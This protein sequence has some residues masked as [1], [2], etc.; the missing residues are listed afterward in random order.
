MPAI[1]P[2]RL[3]VCLSVLAFVAGAAACSDDGGGPSVPVY[4]DGDSITVERGSDFIVALEATPSTGYSWQ[5]APN[6]T[7]RFDSSKQVQAT[8]AA[9]GA[10][11]EQQLRFTAVKKGASLL[12]FAYSRSFE[13]GVPPAMTATFDL[14]VV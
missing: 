13:P 1:R 4:H 5:A 3:G 7:V 10:A 6:D 14:E 8:G 12:E 2:R 9:P 11:G